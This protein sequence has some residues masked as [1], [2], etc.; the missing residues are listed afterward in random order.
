MDRRIHF[1]SGLPRSGSTL[2]AAILRQNPAFMT[3]IISPVAQM[4]AAMQRALSGKSEFHEKIDDGKRRAV[5]RGLV[6]NYFE[7]LAPQITV[8]DTN[9]TWCSKLAALTQL[10]PDAKVIC[11]VRSLAWI[12]DSFERLVARNALE[13]SRLFNYEILGNVYSRVS[14]LNDPQTGVVGSAYRG[15]REAFYGAYSDRLL[16]ITYETLAKTPAIALRAVYEW[17]EA[18]PFTH[19]F[20]RVIFD[21]AEY[22][23]R[24]G[25]RGMH[26]VAGNVRFVERATILPP[27]I[28]R[29]FANTAFWHESAQESTHVRVV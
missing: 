5:L 7:D 2:L 13:P 17:I 24:L 11:C 10:F 26:R 14:S 28:F 8:F 9:R 18:A 29:R 4:F 15:L 12:F 6:F 27:D 20:E 16:L 3:D 1:I 19:D 23:R 25:M 21:A 22:D